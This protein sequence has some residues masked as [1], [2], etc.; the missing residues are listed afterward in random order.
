MLDISHKSYP[1]PLSR[2]PKSTP[3]EESQRA[4]N[5]FNLVGKGASHCSFQQGELDPAGSQ[6]LF[7]STLPIYPL[8]WVLNSQSPSKGPL[9]GRYSR[10]VETPRQSSVWCQDGPLKAS[11]AARSLDWTRGHGHTQRQREK[12][13]KSRSGQRCP[14]ALPPAPFFLRP[15]PDQMSNKNSAKKSRDGTTSISPSAE[16]PWTPRAFPSSSQPALRPHPAPGPLCPPPRRGLPP[17][18]HPGAPRRAGSGPRA[19]KAGAGPERAA[20]VPRLSKPVLALAPAKSRGRRLPIPVR[21]LPRTGVGA[22]SGAH[23][24]PGGPAPLPGG[25][26]RIPGRGLGGRDNSS[27]FPCSPPGAWPGPDSASARPCAPPHTRAHTHSHSLAR[28]HT[29]TPLPPPPLFISSSCLGTQEKPSTAPA[30]RSLRPRPA[31][32]SQRLRYGSSARPFLEWRSGL[33][34]APPTPRVRSTSA[35]GGTH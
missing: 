33:P 20:R 18:G 17:R 19:G 14:P 1:I 11:A 16:P 26:A 35:A 7:Y 21:P 6:S 32:R 12:L 23:V 28:S 13:R 24:R 4:L 31:L 10:L 27:P 3:A 25:G 29:R 8:K 15:A 2:D 5:K 34:P 9:Y 22:T 30:P